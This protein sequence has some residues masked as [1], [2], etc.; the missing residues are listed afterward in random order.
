MGFFKYLIYF[1]MPKIQE[2]SLLTMFGAFI[3]LCLALA[4]FGKLLE[5]F[6]FQ[7]AAGVRFLLLFFNK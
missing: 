2:V 1:Y 6:A 3:I 7:V 5:G 4:T